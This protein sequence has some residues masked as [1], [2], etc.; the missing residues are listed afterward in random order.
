MVE[1]SLKNVFFSTVNSKRFKHFGPQN[2]QTQVYSESQINRD[3]EILCGHPLMTWPPMMININMGVFGM[4]YCFK[5]K[6]PYPLVCIR[7]FFE[8]DKI[9]KKH[10]QFLPNFVDRDKIS[11]SNMKWAGISVLQILNWNSKL[12]KSSQR[13]VAF[14][15]TH[16]HTHIFPLNQH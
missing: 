10:C 7:N 9:F 15:E 4:C 16:T 5:A 6:L 13:V 1:T 14:F 2:W 12:I 11:K 8:T 3:T